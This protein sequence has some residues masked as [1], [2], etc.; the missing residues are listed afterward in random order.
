MSAKKLLSYS[1]L[2]VI[3]AC[4]NGTKNTNEHLENEESQL[5]E[6]TEGAYDVVFDTEEVISTIREH[7]GAINY[8]IKYYDQVSKIVSSADDHTLSLKGY[9]KN[10]ELRKMTT[11]FESDFERLIEEY[12][13]W[14]NELFF[15][16]TQLDSYDLPTDLS[17]Y[18]GDM[19]GEN[20]Y[21]FHNNNLIRWLD[22]EKE[23]VVASK[24]SSKESQILSEVRYLRTR[25][26]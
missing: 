10:G 15:V 22:P 5:L 19:P 16:Y 26:D 6:R 13:F 9:Y 14:D 8:N 12:Y 2:F 3:I 18:Q 21:Y 25:L 24:F 7:Y 23:E 11:R 17:N 4:G 20:R 1:F